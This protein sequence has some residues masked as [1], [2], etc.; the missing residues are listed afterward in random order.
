[1]CCPLLLFCYCVI[2]WCVT[3]N[4]LT[5]NIQQLALESGIFR[6][7]D[8]VLNYIFGGA[9]AST[10]SYSYCPRDGGVDSELTKAPDDS[11]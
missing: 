3:G 5:S 7:K 9:D 11:P 4:L 2:K 6:G 10:R 8:C 1:M